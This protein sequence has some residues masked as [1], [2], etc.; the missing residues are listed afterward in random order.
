M[1]CEMD[2]S[3][4]TI[5]AI[6]ILLSKMPRYSAERRCRGWSRGTGDH[7]NKPTSSRK[8][9]KAPGAALALNEPI[10]FS[11]LIWMEKSTLCFTLQQHCKLL[12]DN[13]FQEYSAWFVCINFAGRLE[14][15]NGSYLL[16]I[17]SDLFVGSIYEV[18][19]SNCYPTHSSANSHPFP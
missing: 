1:L 18:A 17:D 4:V 9:I 10:L 16:S 6:F 8:I 5:W 19:S 2:P 3:G 13:L 14:V 7:S 15:D 11:V 12:L